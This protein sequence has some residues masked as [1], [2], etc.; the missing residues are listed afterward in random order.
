MKYVVQVIILCGVLA[1]SR[2]DI[3]QLIDGDNGLQ[4]FVN[5]YLVSKIKVIDE[6]CGAGSLPSVLDSVRNIV[7]LLDIIVSVWFVE[8]ICCRRRL[9]LSRTSRSFV[10]HTQT[11]GSH[12][13]DS[14][15][16]IKMEAYASG[17]GFSR[18]SCGDWG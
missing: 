3:P 6:V 1:Y 16:W 15:R 11:G 18:N 13:T 9:R 5:D 12:E 8:R 17:R 7:Q 2:A 4:L 14:T 10:A